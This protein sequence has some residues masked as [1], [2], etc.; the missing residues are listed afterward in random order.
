MPEELRQGLDVS[1]SRDEA[2]LKISLKHHADIE[3]RP[4]RSPLS[5]LLF[6]RIHVIPGIANL[7]AQQPAPYRCHLW[8]AQHIRTIEIVGFA[9]MSVGGKRNRRGLGNIP[10]V[11]CRDAPLAERHRVDP[12]LRKRVFQRRVVLTEVVWANNRERDSELP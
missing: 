1:S 3:R 8:T 10:D 2:T 6:E 9:E 12:S 7:L 11:D 4:R 5:H